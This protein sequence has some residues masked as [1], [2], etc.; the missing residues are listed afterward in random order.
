MNMR[1]ILLNG[2]GSVLLNLLKILQLLFVLLVNVLEIFARD[3]ALE[4]LIFLKLAREEGRRGAVRLT[5]D[6]QGR[7]GELLLGIQQERVINDLLLKMAFH[8]V[9][10]SLVLVLVDQTED[11]FERRR[12]ILS[13]LGQ[14]G[15]VRSFGGA[16]LR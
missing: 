14:P 6:P 15:C 4:A 5:V 10:G 2:F 1:C 9:R 7:L 16:C 3:Q 12:V 11:D 13:I 8:V